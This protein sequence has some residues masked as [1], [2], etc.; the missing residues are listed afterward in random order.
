MEEFVLL[1]PLV[2]FAFAA[3]NRF[4]RPGTLAAMIAIGYAAIRFP[5]DFLR[6]AEYEPAQLGLTSGQWGSIVLLVAANLFLL[7]APRSGRPTPS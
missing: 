4:P 6:T 3:R 2:I 1:I 5:L 7:L